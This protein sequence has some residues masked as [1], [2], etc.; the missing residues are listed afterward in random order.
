MTNFDVLVLEEDICRIVRGFDENTANTCM[1]LTSE[2]PANWNDLLACWPRYRTPP[3]VEFPTALSVEEIDKRAALDQLAGRENWVILDLAT[4]RLTTGTGLES[5]G[6]SA[7]F[8]LNDDDSSSHRFPLGI[9]LPPWWQLRE[10]VAIDT[11]RQG[12]DWEEGASRPEK[13]RVDRERLFGLPLLQDLA[14]RMLTTVRSDR[15]KSSGA[16]EDEHRRYQFTVEVHRDW[17]MTPRRDL[18]GRYPRQLL[19]GAH[20]WLSKLMEMQVIR[21]NHGLPMVALPSN[22]SH[23][24]TAPLGSEEVIMYFE[25]CRELIEWGWKWCIKHAADSPGRRSQTVG[26][27]RRGRNRKKIGQAKTRRRRLEN[28]LIGFLREVKE[29]WWNAPFEGGATPKAIIEYS[30]RRVPRVS[31]ITI[32]GTEDLV[33]DNPD[34]HFFDCDCPI[35]KMLSEESFGP[36]IESFDGHH[37]EL[38]DEFAFSMCESKEEWERQQREFES[39]SNDLA[40]GHNEKKW[41]E[42]DSLAQVAGGQQDEPGSE[43]AISA[44]SGSLSDEALPGDSRG[45]MKMA[46]LLAEVVSHLSDGNSPPEVIRELNERFN[47]FRHADQ[48]GDATEA[49][50]RLAN[51]LESLTAA[52]PKLTSRIAD[53]Q[54][55]LDEHLRCA[56]GG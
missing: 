26:F 35:C 8:D 2:D 36:C 24:A 6:G 13:P 21:S 32:V 3:V 43:S 44:W 46:F 42:V 30:R 41:E 38:D 55:R 29:T 19:H 10:R 20:S 51:H 34:S 52:N 54:S 48:E 56:T 47:A 4:K 40:E 1:A 53:F 7:F 28:Q 9:Q 31:G 15:W 16:N 27:K 25:L 50:R 17:L 18:D 23:P 49:A 14:R 45:H 5:H 37:L 39:W 33:D 11:L 22:F 12:Q